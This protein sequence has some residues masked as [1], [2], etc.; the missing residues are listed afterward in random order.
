[1]KNGFKIEKKFMLMYVQIENESIKMDSHSKY[2][3]YFR[4][5]YSVSDS[6]LEM[7]TTA[8]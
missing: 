2:L 6:E 7:S 4:Q 1:M 3:G 5:H 8:L